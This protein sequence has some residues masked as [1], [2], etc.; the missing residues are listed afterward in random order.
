MLIILIVL[1]IV[2]A[3]CIWLVSRWLRLA[4]LPERRF[5]SEDL[6]DVTTASREMAPQTTQGMGGEFSATQ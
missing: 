1:L 2:Y 5:I 4:S 3:C 6:P